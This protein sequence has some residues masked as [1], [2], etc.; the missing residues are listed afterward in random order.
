[1]TRKVGLILDIDTY[2]V[3]YHRLGVSFMDTE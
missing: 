1:M 3:N 2:V